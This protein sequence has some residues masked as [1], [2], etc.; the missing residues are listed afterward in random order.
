[1]L[2]IGFAGIGF[3]PQRLVERTE[4]STTTSLCTYLNIDRWHGSPIPIP[5]GNRVG[6]G[7]ASKI[8]RPA[9][10][11]ARDAKHALAL[12]EEAIRTR[13]LSGSPEAVTD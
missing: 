7:R 2:L 8:R 3:A 13:F 4:Q 6:V 10:T 1:M 9:E 5:R 11:E 12:V